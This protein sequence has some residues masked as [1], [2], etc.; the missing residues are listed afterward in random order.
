MTRQHGTQH[1]KCIQSPRTSDR[2]L[3]SVTLSGTQSEPSYPCFAGFGGGLSSIG[4]AKRL[5]VGVRWYVGQSLKCYRSHATMNVS[6]NSKSSHS[7]RNRQSPE[8]CADDWLFGFVPG[9]AVAPPIVS[10]DDAVLC[11]PFLRLVDRTSVDAD[12]VVGVLSMPPQIYPA[13]PS[14]SEATSASL[15]VPTMSSV[16]PGARLM[17]EPE[18]VIAEP[19]ETSV[20]EPMM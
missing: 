2:N 13:R 11:E 10:H 8:S 5:Y 17:R 9:V 20:C 6:I 7:L 14:V 3:L 16:A 1:R 19:P 15:L 4:C 12:D 18:M